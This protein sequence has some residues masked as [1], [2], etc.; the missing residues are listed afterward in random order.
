MTHKKCLEEPEVK[1]VV[2]VLNYNDY[3]TC[4]D[5]IKSVRDYEIID[6]III[7]DNHSTDESVSELSQYTN[8]KIEFIETDFNRGYAYGNNYGMRYATQKYPNLEYIIISNPDIHVKETDIRKIISPLSFEYS[9]STGVIY[10]YNP[11]KNTKGLASNFGWKLPTYWDMLSNCYIIFY[12][13]KRKVFHTSMYLD[14]EKEKS[15]PIIDSEAVP[16]CF[17]VIRSDAAKDIDYFDEDTFLFG[18]ESILGYRLR[19]KNYKVCIVNDTEV[20]HENSVSI[21]K[22]IKANKRKQQYR[23]DAELVYLKKYLHSNKFLLGF[24]IINYK[25]GLFEKRLVYKLLRLRKREN[26]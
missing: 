14:W 13:M 24:Y 1:L 15:K 26:K 5:F 25:I 3:L 9:L 19:E 18:E 17:F 12:K 21:N 7:V 10:N 16:G 23:L 6:K 22:N 11:N 8:E 4:I 2:V 20:L